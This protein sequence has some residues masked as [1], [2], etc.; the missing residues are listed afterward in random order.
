MNI[1]AQILSESIRQS[2]AFVGY[3]RADN[4]VRQKRLRPAC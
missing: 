4:L 1:A 2:V 3:A